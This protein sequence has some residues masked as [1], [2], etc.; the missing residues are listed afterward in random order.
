MSRVRWDG[1]RV[2]FE[3]RSETVLVATLTDGGRCTTLQVVHVATDER[4]R[5]VGSSLLVAFAQLCGDAGVRRIDVDDM[6]DRA[7]TVKHNLYVKHGFAYRNAHGPEM[8]TSPK[9]ILQTARRDL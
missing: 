3:G 8:Y 1:P 2:V 5:G 9:T 7:R 4:G 6:S